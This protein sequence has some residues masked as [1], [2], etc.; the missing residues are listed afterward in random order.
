MLRNSVG[1]MTLTFQASKYCNA[2]GFPEQC[3]KVSGGF[4]GNIATGIIRT[5]QTYDRGMLS[6]T[7]K[8][9]NDNVS[10]YNWFI[11]LWGLY[12]ATV[13]NNCLV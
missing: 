9:L 13:Y 8:I 12:K 7:F 6:Q 4:S 5:H 11:V 2:Y 1:L 3:I 10:L